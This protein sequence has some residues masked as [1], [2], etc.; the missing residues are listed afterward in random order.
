MRQDG[1]EAQFQVN[2]LASY[3]LCRLFVPLLE[4]TGTE[5]NPAR[6]VIV[7]SLSSEK[8]NLKDEPY[9]SA[10]AHRKE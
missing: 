10:V 3:L 5:N 1:F 6:V 2:Y 8:G 9:L 4:S 7:S